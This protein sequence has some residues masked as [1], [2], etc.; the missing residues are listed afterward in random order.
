MAGAVTYR[1]A[2]VDIAAADGWLA[3]MQP[4]I[5]TTMRPEVLRDRGQFAGLF[6][7]PPG[8]WR[9][10]VLV[11]STDGVGTKLKVAQL[12]GRHEDIG[13]DAVAMNTNDILVYGA[14]PLFFLDYLAVGRIQP[15]L[16]SALL[17]GIVRGCRES[18]CV[19]LGGETAEMPGLY[20]EGE[21]DVAGFCVG[22]VEQSRLLD[23]S[24]VRANDVIIGLASNGVH[25]NGFSLVRR[26]LSAPQLKRLAPQLL[27]P[28]RIYVKPVLELLRHVRVHAIAHVTGGG[29]ARRLP[30]LVAKTRGMRARLTPGSWRVPAVFQ[31]IQRSGGIRTDEMYNTFNMGIGMAL[32]CAP[33]DADRIVRFFARARIKAWPI[34]YI[35]RIRSR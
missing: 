18:G 12:A 3:R 8:R 1:R 23:G 27:R 2:G 15:K 22:V 17:R 14:E 30:S 16:M 26:A 19:L 9:N 5:R 29:L 35:E 33:S 20:G 4:L 28:T 10:P 11:A 31:A 24:R 7:L 34:G 32:A 13:V 21:Y 6:R 25:A